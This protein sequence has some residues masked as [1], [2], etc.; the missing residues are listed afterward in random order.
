V[1][2]GFALAF[3]GVPGATYL[4]H[5]VPWWRQ[6]LIFLIT[7]VAV[8]DAAIYLVAAR[9]PWRRRPLGRRGSSR[10]SPSSSSAST[11]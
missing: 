1:T 3:A 2:R 4:A 5:L 8:I 7:L 10:R 9:G 6:P 11:C